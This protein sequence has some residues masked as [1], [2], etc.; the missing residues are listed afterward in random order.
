MFFQMT[1]ILIMCLTLVGKQKE[2][3]ENI[4]NAGMIIISI[5]GGA[6]G[7]LSTVYLLFSLPAV[8]IWKIYRRFRFGYSLFN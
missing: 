1:E 6:S 8:I 4:M 7:I 3:E 2:S 5:I